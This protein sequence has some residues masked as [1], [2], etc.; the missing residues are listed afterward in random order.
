MG[1]PNFEWD[2][3]KA[4]TNLRKHGVSFEEARTVFKD[5]NFWAQYDPAHLGPESRLK[6]VGIS[7]KN[8]LL[9]VIFTPRNDAI[10]I[11]N[12]RKATAGEEAAYAEGLS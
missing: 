8:R 4:T 1:E 5:P 7:I 12:A 3:R 10:R 9:A 2:P 6:A 11:I